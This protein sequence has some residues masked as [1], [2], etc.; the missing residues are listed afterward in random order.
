MLK[1]DNFEIFIKNF[2]ISVMNF[3]TFDNREINF[4]IN[5]KN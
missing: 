3:Q 1:N 2:K 4:E 5:N